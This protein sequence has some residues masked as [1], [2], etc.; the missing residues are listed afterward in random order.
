MSSYP[1]NVGCA[2][3]NVREKHSHSFVFQMRYQ[4]APDN[5]EVSDLALQINTLHV[6]SK[7]LVY[8]K[9]SK[10][11]IFCS[12]LQWYVKLRKSWNTCSSSTGKQRIHRCN[13]SMAHTKL[14]K[15]IRENHYSVFNFSFLA[16]KNGASKKFTPVCQ[17]AQGLLQY[18]LHIT[19]FQHDN[20][21]YVPLC[22]LL[23][24]ICV[25]D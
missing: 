2:D 24:P 7:P 16:I 21:I 18:Y 13:A 5:A 17:T 11:W 20:N 25:L 1:W 12:D 23:H 8:L 9:T 4:A 22:F 10:K 15:E 3:P 14:Q 6:S 19:L